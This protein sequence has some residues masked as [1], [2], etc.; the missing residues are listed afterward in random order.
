VGTGITPV[1]R[2]E[3]SLLLCR[4]SR[5]LPAQSFAALDDEAILLVQKPFH[6]G[7]FPA[8]S[9]DGFGF[10]A[11]RELNA[12]SGGNALV[13]IESIQRLDFDDIFV[14]LLREKEDRSLPARSIARAICLANSPV[15]GPASYPVRR[16]RPPERRVRCWSRRMMV[17]RRIDFDPG[18]RPSE[19][20]LRR[21][22]S[23][24]QFSSS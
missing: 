20:P 1:Q 2:G 19:Q 18:T 22:L 14:A 3:R 24:S 6:A 11:T 9:V 10:A 7:L 15:S 4:R 8:A 5:L 13:D 21:G 23:E 17:P 12:V 16:V